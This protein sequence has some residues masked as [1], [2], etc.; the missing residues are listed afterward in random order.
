M[1]N[2]E[3]VYISLDICEFFIPVFMRVCVPFIDGNNEGRKTV[4][5]LILSLFNIAALVSRSKFNNEIV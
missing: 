5:N 3:N 4:S 2:C 1:I